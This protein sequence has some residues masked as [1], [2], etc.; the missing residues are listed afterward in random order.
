MKADEILI[1]PILSE[2]SSLLREAKNKTYVFQV[3]KQS[4]KIEIMKAVKTMF[5]IEPLSCSIV[6]VR[7]KKR[8]NIP[9]RGSVKRG[10][11]KTASWKKAYVVLPEGKTIAEL[12]A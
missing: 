11:G 9:Y 6:N 4:N 2:K 5:N 1:R 10:H 3:A 7:G 8:A 12:E